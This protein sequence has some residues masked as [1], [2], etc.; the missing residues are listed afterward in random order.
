MP[1]IDI[2]YSN[3]IIYKIFCKDESVNDVYVGH[4]TNFIK[5]K[6][7]HKVACNNLNNKLKIY[8]I[9]RENGGWSNWDMIE[10]AKYNCNDHTEARIK[11]QEHYE[12]LKS[13]L[14]SCPPYSDKK[15]YYCTFCDTQCNSKKEHDIH[16]SCKI[17]NKNKENNKILENNNYSKKFFC[18]KCNYGS[19]KKS[20]WDQHL[21][22]TKHQKSSLE[23]MEANKEYAC[24][25]CTIKFKHQ[26][27]YC[28][29]KKKCLEIN[30]ENDKVTLT[31]KELIMIL[32]KQN[33]QLI[34]QNVELMKNC[35]VTNK[36]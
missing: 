26:S 32:I 7:S 1:K 5:R 18:E 17:H 4:T 31:D 14:N 35:F 28:R 23:L 13:T 30:V 19:T 9:I 29:H 6:Y 8:N 12:M 25:K 2:D 36:E 34:E 24:E 21:L 16:L 10:I 22:T 11:E 33:K 3:T 20:C 27:S 15:Q